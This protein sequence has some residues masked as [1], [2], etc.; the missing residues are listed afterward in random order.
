MNS[1]PWKNPE[2]IRQQVT[3]LK[4]FQLSNLAGHTSQIQTVLGQR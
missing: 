4:E 3:D 2:F 1:V